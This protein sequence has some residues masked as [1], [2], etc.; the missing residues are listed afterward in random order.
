MRNDCWRRFV[1]TV[2]VLTLCGCGGA[3]DDLGSVSGTV[4]LDGA[5]LENAQIEFIP[6]EGGSTAYG[7]TDADGEYEMMFTRDTRGAS[8]GENEVRITT[9]DVTM[10]DG[11][12]VAIPER[13]PA[14]YNRNSE[15]K[16]TVESGSNTFD[17]SLVSEG[18]IS[19][20]KL[21]EQ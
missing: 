1:L 5:P 3:R 12:E 17:F 13:V 21:V 8:L 20:P 16:Q 4:T 19:Q 11:N 14:K 15:L 7:R 10:K 6:R 9:A 18:K 2:G